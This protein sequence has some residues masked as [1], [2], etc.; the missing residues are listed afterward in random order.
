MIGALHLHPLSKIQQMRTALNYLDDYDEKN[1]SRKGRM[2]DDD[3][4]EKEDKKPKPAAQ[5]PPI[6]ALRKVGPTELPRSYGGR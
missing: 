3:D 4:E 6:R 2:N 5:G 1:R